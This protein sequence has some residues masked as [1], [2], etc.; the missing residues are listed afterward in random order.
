MLHPR[1]PLRRLALLLS[2]CSMCWHAAHASDD[3]RVYTDDRHP[4]SV[5]PGLAIKVVKLDEAQRLQSTLS[6]NLPT[7][8]AQAEVIVRQRFA[9]GGATWQARMQQA[10]QGVTDAWAMGVEKVPAVVVNRRYVVYGEAD[11]NKALQLIDHYRR[12]HP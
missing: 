6:A 10:Y 2:T 9:Q 7:D 8:Q 12:A 4:I 3:V 11:V 5:Q 1:P